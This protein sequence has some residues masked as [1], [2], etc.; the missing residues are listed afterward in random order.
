MRGRDLV[1][2]PAAA[3]AAVVQGLQNAEA[4]VVQGAQVART[5]PETWFLTGKNGGNAGMMSIFMINLQYVFF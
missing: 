5:T 3:A 1:A 2:S 4:P